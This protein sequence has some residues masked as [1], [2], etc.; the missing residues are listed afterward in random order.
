MKTEHNLET[1]SKQF[2]KNILTEGGIALLLILVIGGICFYLS[3]LDEEFTQDSNKMRSKVDGILQ[4][5]TSLQEKYKFVTENISLYEEIITNQ[6]NSGLLISKQLMFEK[7]NQFKNQFSLANLRVSVSPVQDSKDPKLKTKTN[8]VKYS[9]VSL[10]FDTLFDENVYNLLAKMQT[11]LS[12]I[13]VVSKLSM[14][15]LKVLDAAILKTIATDGAYPL[16]KTNITFNWYSI[17]S[18]ESNDANN[19]QPPNA[20]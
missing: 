12:G 10:D 19:N 18:I 17:N 20:M 4:E 7:F 1:K 8:Q 2:T 13:S 5:Y 9:E 11:E 15:Q 3:T 16:I 14:T 6:K